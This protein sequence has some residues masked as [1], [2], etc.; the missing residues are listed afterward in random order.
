MSDTTTQFQRGSFL[1][2][3][4][5]HATVADV[6]H[7]GILC[8]DPNASLTKVARVMALDHVHCVAVMALA[9]DGSGESLVWGMISDIDVLEA[10]LEDGAEPTARTLAKQPVITVRPNTPLREAGQAMVD[11]AVTH[12]VVVD[13]ETQRPIGI[14]STLDIAGVLAWGEA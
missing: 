9:R 6:M 8:C 5:S 12:L 13:P 2:P 4:L 1:V 3:T 7:P 11:N 14:I 10:G